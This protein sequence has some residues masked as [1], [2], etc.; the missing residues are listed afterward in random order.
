LAKKIAVVTL[1]QNVDEVEVPEIV[2]LN[3]QIRHV[4][5]SSLLARLWRLDHVAFMNDTSE[6]QAE[7]RENVVSHNGPVNGTIDREGTDVDSQRAEV[8]VNKIPCECLCC[9]V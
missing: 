3:H 9:E 5:Q 4:L 1:F 7:T 6:N 8:E 2:E